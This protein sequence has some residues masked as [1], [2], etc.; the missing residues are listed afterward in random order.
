ME[1]KRKFIF[2]L[3]GSLIF[4]FIML[5]GPLQ[6]IADT[7]TT[8]N[9]AALEIIDRDIAE[10][11]ARLTQGLAL[12]AKLDSK[13]STIRNSAQKMLDAEMAMNDLIDNIRLNY[14][15]NALK[16]QGSLG[17]SIAFLGPTALVPATTLAD[18]A[19]TTFNMFVID[20]AMGE[21]GNWMG[22]G[23]PMEAHKKHAQSYTDGT[24][25]SQN[26]LAFWLAERPTANADILERGRQII[27]YANQG[28][29]EIR[30]MGAEMRTAY[31][32]MR[33]LKK[34][35]KAKLETLK[36]EIE[37]LKRHRKFTA[38]DIEKPEPVF[39]TP[40]DQIATIPSNAGSSYR[41]GSDVNEAISTLR[42]LRQRIVSNNANI[43][44]AYK[45]LKEEIDKIKEDINL[46]YQDGQ[47]KHKK[48]ISTSYS[49]L[50]NLPYATINS[51]SHF[52]APRNVSFAQSIS[53]TI[54]LQAAYND[55]TAAHIRDLES[56]A[57]ACSPAINK[58]KNS[59]R[60]K[61]LRE[62]Y[63]IDAAL[64]SR[65]NQIL[66]PWSGRDE[67][68]DAG[69]SSSLQ[70]RGTCFG[71]NGIV[72]KAIIFLHQKEQAWFRELQY[73]K[74]TFESQKELHKRTIPE[75]QK[76]ARDL[77][78]STKLAL[79]YQLKRAKIGRR[80]TQRYTT[81]ARTLSAF[82]ER[83]KN[84]QILT[85]IA[86]DG[87]THYQVSDVWITQQ[88]EQT[89]GGACSGITKIL[90]QLKVYSVRMELLEE[91]AMSA[92]ENA[93]Q[94]ATRVASNY[95]AKYNIPGLHSEI[96]AFLSG[97]KREEENFRWA[98]N[99]VVGSDCGLV[100]FVKN[101][102]AGRLHMFKDSLPIQKL[103]QLQMQETKTQTNA[104]KQLLVIVENSQ[105]QKRI[106]ST[107]Q[108]GFAS[109]LQ[110]YKKR[111]TM[112]LQCLGDD[113]I[114]N[115]QI[116]ELLPKLEE[117]INKL[118]G[119]ATYLDA[120]QQLT[121]LRLL[122][123]TAVEL[124]LGEDEKYKKQVTKIE[125]LYKNQD[126]WLVEHKPLMLSSVT[127]EMTGLL[128]EIAQILSIHRE[129]LSSLDASAEHEAQNTMITNF[130]DSFK[131]A[132]ESKNESLVMNLIADDWSSADGVTLFD[133]EDNLRNMYNVY[134]DIQ[135]T[136]SGL[137]I[138]RAGQNI[139]NVS[140]SVTIRGEIFDNDLTHEEVSSVTEQLIL[141]GSGKPKIYRTLGGSYWSIQ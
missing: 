105:Q 108:Q 45:K 97:S 132:Y 111:Y 66:Q 8:D 32:S 24:F 15:N 107:A 141:D 114:Y 125:K 48:R 27:N 76:L 99:I 33:D 87:L 22:V 140:Y 94:T 10:K 20:P 72:Q 12:Y 128:R 117:A 82:R 92:R 3:C 118:N 137:N 86:E 68:R 103:A 30:T 91:A 74:S 138:S 73:E 42:S 60:I 36:R 26:R 85:A 113:H 121:E 77:I 41:M 89:D 70:Q 11:Q 62:L 116:V 101:M 2:R 78:S 102:E 21:I 83:L 46:L 131:Q 53:G 58:I 122:K 47:T 130:Y 84:Q 90:Q 95:I 6:A 9:S 100:S 54:Q 43:D 124:T 29:G 63:G 119:K 39:L 106:S 16:I 93:I 44:I 50:G 71:R 110:K 37:S 18:G 23:N 1:M 134:D 35:F 61:E 104:I 136:I 4:I 38:G 133:L 17:L 59:Q 19:L 139:Y 79:E 98:E 51:L 109:A 13:L 112:H 75:L 65:Y 67:L 135:Y 56:I 80:A 52:G 120:S 34:S 129:H 40:P 126:T 96:T 5:A 49:K 31:V 25:P 69:L 115:R 127:E 81:T 28:R 7:E 88:L 64:V 14:Q 55:Y 123:D 57:S